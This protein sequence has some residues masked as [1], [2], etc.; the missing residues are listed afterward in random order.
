MAALA[1]AI[2]V[3]SPAFAQSSERDPGIRVAPFAGAPSLFGT[4]AQSP[5]GAL[6]LRE[7]AVEECNADARIYGQTIYGH[8]ELDRYRACM[9]RKGHME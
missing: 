4:Y 1:F 3:S 6:G 7:T 2:L 8:Q 5:P 9:A